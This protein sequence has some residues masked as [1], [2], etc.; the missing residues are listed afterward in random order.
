M[1]EEHF[2]AEAYPNRIRMAELPE[3]CLLIPNQ[4]NRIPGFTLY[5][6]HFFPGFPE[7]AWPMLDWVLASYYPSVDEKTGEC[8]VQIRGATESSLYELMESL[9]VRY[10]ELKLFSLPHMGA[11]KY[12]EL[13]FRGREPL[14]ETAFADLI[15]ELDARNVAF[16][17]DGRE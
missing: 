15:A 16:E 11:D 2:G 3:D 13:G 8:S 14:L 17:L 4:F 12:I 7:L 1:I 5:E 6:H 9:S 10:R